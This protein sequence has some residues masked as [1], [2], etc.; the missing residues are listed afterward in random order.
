MLGWPSGPRRRFAK[1]VPVRER[2]FESH[3]QRLNIPVY[4]YRS[5]LMTDWVILRFPLE[6][7]EK[8]EV[9]EVLANVPE[10]WKAYLEKTANRTKKKGRYLVASIKYN[11]GEAFFPAQSLRFLIQPVP[12]L[13]EKHRESTPFQLVRGQVGSERCKKVTSI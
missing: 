3:S 1:P 13:L 9:I 5:D 12:K 2:E 4:R 6:E 10:N 11:L 7:P 8:P